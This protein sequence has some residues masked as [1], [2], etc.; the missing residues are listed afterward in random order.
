MALFSTVVAN[1]FLVNTIVYHMCVPT[2]AVVMG[3]IAGFVGVGLLSSVNLSTQGTGLE[4]SSLCNPEPSQM[5]VSVAAT[6]STL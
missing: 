3:V 2:T 1:L 4:L 5:A 6:I